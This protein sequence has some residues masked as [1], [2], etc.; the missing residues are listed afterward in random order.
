MDTATT[1]TMRAVTPG[2]HGPAPLAVYDHAPVDGVDTVPLAWY[3][4]E[5]YELVRT[6]M[7]DGRAFPSTFEK[8]QTYATEAEAL[9][10]AK[11]FAPIRVRL[12]PNAFA[13]WCRAHGQ[14]PDAKARLTFGEWATRSRLS[15]RPHS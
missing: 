3:D 2:S 8:W 10:S 14:Q 7:V 13:R 11:G 15:T 12:D 9:F 1:D 4:A 6:L 5:S